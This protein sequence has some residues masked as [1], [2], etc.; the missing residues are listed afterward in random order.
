[1]FIYVVYNIAIRDNS[2][3]Q[4]EQNFT[5]I[6]KIIEPSFSTTLLEDRFLILQKRVNRV[7]P[8]LPKID[9][10]GFVYAK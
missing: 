1:M 10:K 3:K 5:K 2:I 7:Y 6:T 4:K 8:T 9:K